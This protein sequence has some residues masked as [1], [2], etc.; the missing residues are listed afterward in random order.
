MEAARAFGAILA[1]NGIGLVYGGGSVGMM[2]A[3]AQAVLEHGGDVTG[4]IPEFLIA[5]EHALQAAR[6]S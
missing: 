2:G 6:T 5:R 1:E 4:I 3:I